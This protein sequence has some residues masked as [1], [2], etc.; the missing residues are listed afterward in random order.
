MPQWVASL[1]LSGSGSKMTEKQTIAID[2]LD[3][4]ASEAIIIVR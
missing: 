1:L 4:K 2:V 3:H